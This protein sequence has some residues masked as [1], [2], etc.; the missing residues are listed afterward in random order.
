MHD[1]DNFA[2]KNKRVNSVLYSIH[3]MI[4]DFLLPL[5]PCLELVY[6]HSARRY[7][8]YILSGSVSI[9]WLLT[10]EGMLL[11]ALLW[12]CLCAHAF[13]RQGIDYTE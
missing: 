2:E 8:T 4:M 13:L 1:F 11:G 6:K 3:S 7:H 12:S 9:S 5:Q 10:R